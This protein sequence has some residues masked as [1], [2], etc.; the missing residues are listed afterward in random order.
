MK[1][2]VSEKDIVIMFLIMI[3]FIILYNRKGNYEGFELSNDPD[4]IIMSTMLGK[5]Y[6]NRISK[7]MNL[8]KPSLNIKV[9]NVE[10]LKN[11]CDHLIGKPKL[12]IARAANPYNP[13]WI[14]CLQRMEEKGVKVMNPPKV[15]QLTSNKLISSIHFMN[16]GL[17]HP[18]SKDGKHNDVKTIKTIKD[19]LQKY[20]KVIIKPYTSSAQGKYV[21]IID[22]TMNDATIKSK[23]KLIPTSQ[24]VIQEY[25]PYLAIYRVIVVNNKAL[26]LSYKDVPNGDK[27]KVS[28]CLNPN[29]QFI[30]NP[31]PKLLR[32]AERVQRSILDG[33]V[34][35]ID[36]FE[37]KDGSYTISEVN[38]ACSL[39][40]HERK[41][42]AVNH[43]YHNIAHHL[44]KY[45]VTLTN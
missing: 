6:A 23:I 2:K 28:V 44:A 22:K 32:T 17:P 33:G 30:A 11:Q 7:E 42:K 25:V 5:A 34:H 18:F 9:L 41:A 36:L 1:I 27:W 20:N 38:T 35:F 29:M 8:I 24:F 14:K 37:L 4:V 39:L 40:L 31:D 15:L 12:I 3:L 16:E 45:Y 19:M 26:P 43:K 21:Q 10:E 13:G